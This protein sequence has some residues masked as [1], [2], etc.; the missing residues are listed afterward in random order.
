MEVYVLGCG[1]MM[2]L[3]GRHLT[4]VLVRREGELILFDCGE[5]TQ[6]SLKRLNLKW[7][8]ISTIYISHTHA[9]HITGL[10]GI[11]ML[12]AQVDRTEPLT[13]IGPKKIKEYIETS[14]SVLDMYI[15]YEIIIK[16]L[17]DP[18]TSQIVTDTDEYYVK[19]IPLDHSKV[20]VGYSLIEKERP[21]VFFPDKAKEVGV[22][23][24]PM[25][26]ILQSGKN[27]TLEDGREISPGEVMGDI[28]KGRKF[29]YVT[30]TAYLPSIAK[31]VEG[32]DLFICEGMFEEA[33]LESAKE[34]KHMISKQSAQIALDG[35]VKQLGLIHY[36]PRYMEKELRVLLTEAQT[37]F[38][39]TVLTRDRMLFNLPHEE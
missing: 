23:V 4:S 35:N 12:S 3:P 18:A 2:P 11:L 38:K 5:A 8:R 25:W 14:I 6:I 34:K 9:D 27:V 29:S 13:I 1:G 31:E 16:E 10:P 30:D 39:N 22:P 28:R 17:E 7:K 37:I 36:S 20:C 32:S 33:L 21:G 19:T 24:G 26:S 15:N